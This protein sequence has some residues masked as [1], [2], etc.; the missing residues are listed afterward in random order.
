METYTNN[1]G[2]KVTKWTS[3]KHPDNANFMQTVFWTIWEKPDG[4]VSV[5][6][7]L[8]AGSKSKFVYNI[9]KETAINLYS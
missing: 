1:F 7:N 3:N 6:Y 4:R 9:D 8:G 5:A 2:E